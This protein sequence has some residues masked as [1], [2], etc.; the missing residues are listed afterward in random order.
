MKS[1]YFFLLFFFLIPFQ[2]FSQQ[3]LLI[4]DEFGDWNEVNFSHLDPEG[5]QTNGIIDFRMVKTANDSNNIYFY[6]E[7]T[8]EINLQEQ[9]QISLYIDCDNNSSTGLQIAGIG[10][11]LQYTFGTRSGSVRLNGQ[12]TSVRHHHVGMFSAPT[13][14]SDKFEIAFN[15][16]VKI[17]NNLLFTSNTIKF[18]LRDNSGGDQVPNSSGGIEYTFSNSNINSTLPSYSIKKLN[19]SHIRFLSY[20]VE[21]DGFFDQSK[22]QFFSRV[23]KAINPDIIGFQEIYNNSSLAAAQ[24][25]EEILPS[26]SGQQWY[27]AKVNPDIIIVSR[28]PIQ[29]VAAIDGNG[30]FLLNLENSY[31][32]KMLV[33]VA[34]TPCCANNDARQLEID[35]IM[36]FIR[37]AK[38]GTGQINLVYGT[39]IVI[40]GDM[41]LVGYS[42][43]LK[44]FLEGDIINENIYGPD[45][46]PDWDESH[47]KD[48]KPII[49]NKPG[50]FTWYD[51]GS[52]YP[53]GRLDYQ[54]YSGS[55]LE[56]KNGFALFTPSLPNDTLTFYQLQ[57]NDVT[58][59]ADHLPIIT[60]FQFI[61]ITH[62]S[63]NLEPNSFELFQNYPNP[64]NNSTTIKFSLQKESFLK[65]LIHNSLGELIDIVYQGTLLSGIHSIKFSSDA[66]GSG[67]YYY[68]II[69]DERIESKKMIFLK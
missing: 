2:I 23:I 62:I 39:P 3:Y 69:T 41:N 65:I 26:S 32:T 40:M 13:I 10:A 58:S 22:S 31:N 20:N 35:A 56:K 61:P 53:P 18:V 4:N 33:I 15:R 51:T 45:F 52:S 68:S 24:K 43:Q 16:N 11:E 59:A 1:C 14:T 67:V 36:A 46:N 60:D 50:A 8:A 30:A 44:T 5:D 34:H 9:N 55:V 28:F 6:F 17:N 47:F 25:V 48:A 38:N 57:V 42:Q 63:E 7:T 19:N 12:T 27:H 66:L 54:I 64:F 21:L 49:T 29:S 37:N